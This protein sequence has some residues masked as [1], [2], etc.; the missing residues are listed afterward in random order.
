MAIKQYKNVSEV[1]SKYRWNLE[2]LLEGKTPAQ[3]L[4]DLL[5]EANQLIEIKDSKFDSAESYLAARAI[6]DQISIK[7]NKFYNYVSNKTSENVVEAETAKLSAK[8]SHEMAEYESK[9]GSEE[10]RILAN[11]SKI[12]EW[13]KRKD[14]KPYA[15][16]LKAVLES[17]KHKLSDDVEN[18]LT[19][20]SFG[21]VSPSSI[22]TIIDNSETKYKDITNSK[23]KK[24]KVTDATLPSLYKSSDA[25]VRKDARI[26]FENAYLRHKNSL[27]ALLFDE[28][29][30]HV[31]V[32]KVR[33]YPSTIEMHTYGDRVDLK[34]VETLYE[35]VK[36]GKEVFRKFYQNHKKFYKAKFNET[37]TRFDGA[38]ELVKVKSEYSVPEMQ[39]TV[40]KALEPFGETYLAQIRKAFDENWV[41]YMTID[42]KRSGAYSI[43]ASYGL[44]KKYILMNYDGQLRSVETLAH[45][46]GHSMHSYFSDSCLSLEESQYPIFLAE[47]AS[48]FNE[49]MLY[50]HLLKTSNSDKLKFYIL[51]QMITGYIGTVMRQVE[52]SNYE[53]KLYKA[54]ESGEGSPTYDFLSSLYFEN[55]KEYNYKVKNTSKI[56]FK[57]EEQIASIYVPHF[58]MDFY[59]YKYAIGQL[60]ANAFFARYQKQGPQALQDYIDN[61]LSAGGKKWPL[62]ILKDNGIDL[63]DP[64]VYEDGFNNVKSLID[65]WVTIGNRLFKK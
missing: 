56:K 10:V 22:F 62:E 19:K 24:I 55:S 37:M 35:Q 6:E 50:D 38:R 46:L 28:F 42:N 11:E 30:S 12:A 41:D 57:E 9:M 32:A 7:M 65:Q 21:E 54:I 34:F 5:T 17:K 20:V 2:V 14:F 29:K 45:E 40:L 23:G 61:F 58:Y 13:I 47:I 53:Y 39:E 48:I 64:Q 1:E 15:H 18:Y 26:S 33:N 60:V 3:A 59:V 8:F 43:G 4:E 27:S 63:Y 52:W 49:L 44:E 51:D 16:N 36:K 31:A 25:K